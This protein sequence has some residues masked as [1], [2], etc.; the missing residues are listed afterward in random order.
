[1]SKEI[2]HFS[3]SRFATLWQ[4]DCEFEMTGKNSIKLIEPIETIAPKEAQPQWSFGKI[5]F[6][7]KNSK[8]KNDFYHDKGARHHDLVSV[9]PILVQMN[10]GI[11]YEVGMPKIV[12]N[13]KFHCWTLE[14][15]ARSNSRY[16]AMMNGGMEFYK[17]SAD[18]LNA[19]NYPPKRT[20]RM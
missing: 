15:T 17:T 11:W 18:D 6:I 2:K 10:N 12:W 3:V 8:E 20:Q 7:N 19:L 9:A 5:E 16:A 4:C 13:E 1:M 14:R